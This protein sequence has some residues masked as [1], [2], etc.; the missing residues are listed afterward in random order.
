LPMY[1]VAGIYKTSAVLWAV[2]ICWHFAGFFRQRKF[3]RG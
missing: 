1:H 3:S 2:S